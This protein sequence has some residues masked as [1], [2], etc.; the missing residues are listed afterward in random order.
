[1]TKAKRKPKPSMTEAQA[2]KVIRQSKRIG[3][4]EGVTVKSFEELLQAAEIILALLGKTNIAAKID[5]NEAEEK[6]G[7][8]SE[9]IQNK[10]IEISQINQKL[11][12]AEN[13]AEISADALNKCAESKDARINSLLKRL[14]D[15]IIRRNAIASDLREF[16]K[17]QG[18]MAWHS[19]PDFTADEEKILRYAMDELGGKRP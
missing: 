9:L 16:M 14:K 10:N 19:Q 5:L 1:M 6:I 15:Q 12:R 3:D 17:Y 11:R 18:R 7:R 13:D 2:K 8:L 4:F